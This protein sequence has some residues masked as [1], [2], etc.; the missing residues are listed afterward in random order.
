[1]EG[2]LVRTK[3]GC[4]AMGCVEADQIEGGRGQGVASWVTKRKK[5]CGLRE[6]RRKDFLKIFDVLTR[7]NIQERMCSLIEMCS[8]QVV[9]S[10]RNTLKLGIS[11]VAHIFPSEHT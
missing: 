8:G 4:A 11:K 6:G 3:G 10:V 7:K 5:G 9:S 1:M 2:R